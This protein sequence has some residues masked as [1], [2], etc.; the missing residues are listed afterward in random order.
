MYAQWTTVHPPV[1]QSLGRGY[2]GFAY[3]RLS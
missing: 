1:T 2:V 3:V